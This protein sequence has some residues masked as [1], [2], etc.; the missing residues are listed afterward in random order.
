MPQDEFTKLFQYIQRMEAKID[1]MAETM[2]TKEDIQN[3][4]KRLDS[5]EKQL[6]ISEDERLVMGHQLERLNRWVQELAAKIGYEL[7]A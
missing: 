7:T 3:I 4:L 5:I 1:V 2:A 6:E